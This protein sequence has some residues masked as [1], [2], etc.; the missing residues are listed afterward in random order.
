MEVPVSQLSDAERAQL[1]KE[2]G[3]KQIGTELP[4]GV[5]LTDIVKTMPSEVCTCSIASVSAQSM[6]RPWLNEFLST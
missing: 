5:S 2:W 4:D 1:A 3:F 6:L